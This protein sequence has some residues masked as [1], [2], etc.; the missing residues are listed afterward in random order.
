MNTVN[1]GGFRGAWAI[2]GLISFLFSSE[3]FA[4]D[5]TIWTEAKPA[6]IFAGENKSVRVLIKNSA[7]VARKIK[8]DTR[9]FEVAK[10]ISAPLGERKKWKEISIEAGETAV[11]RF[12]L[13]LPEVR[14]TTTLVLKF[15]EENN[16]VELG[17]ILLLVYPEDLLA[18]LG[19][20]SKSD[21]LAVLDDTVFLRDR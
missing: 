9:T 4:A 13:A 19:R 8:V 15:Y 6:L 20:V 17:S 12:P 5:L 7:A 18:E 1:L 14:A 16:V 3:L 10:A 21:W 2:C 11:E